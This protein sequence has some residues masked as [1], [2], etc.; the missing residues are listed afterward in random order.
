MVNGRTLGRIGA[1]TIAMTCV[2]AASADINLEW[3][4]AT[5][6]VTV[7]NTVNLGLYAVSDDGSDQSISAMDV[8]ISWD[9]GYLDL[10]GVSDDG[11][12]AW[13]ASG[14]PNDAALDGV[15]DSLADGDALYSA[16]AALGS[17][18]FATPAG[19]LVTTFQFEALALTV[20]TPLTIPPTFGTFTETEVFDGAVPGLGVH[21]TLGAATVTIV[22]E[23][24]SLALLVAGVGLAVRRGRAR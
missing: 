2:Q 17:P 16:Y 11:P 24:G 9:S 4:P 5:P 21:G 8:I 20:G 6:T 12:Y 19:L 10:L 3:R 14:F 18:A 15:N 1:W 22:P 23:P 13:I 7:G